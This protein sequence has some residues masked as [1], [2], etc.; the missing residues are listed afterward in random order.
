VVHHKTRRIPSYVAA[1]LAITF[2]VGCTDAAGPNDNIRKSGINV[3]AAS[4]RPSQVVSD[5]VALDVPGY[6]GAFVKNGVLNVYLLPT[7]N[8]EAGRAAARTAITDLL[9]AGNRPPM[10]IEF[11]PAR[12]SLR[13][14]RAWER[15]LMGIYHRA[16]VSRA[17]VDERN[18]RFD[19]TVTST[20]GEQDVRDAAARLGI[21]TEDVVVRTNEPPVVPFVDLHDRVRPAGGGLAISTFVGGC[22]Y[23]FNAWINDGVG[24]R[25]MVTN[26][27]CVQA[28]G[29]GGTTGTFV[30][31]PASP[32]ANQVGRV[33]RNPAAT[34]NNVNCAPGDVCRESDAALVYTDATTAFPASSWD[35]GGISATTSRGVGPNSNGSTTIS[36]RIT[37]AN[38]S[39][40]FFA[41]DTLEKIGAT[42]GWTAGVVTATC[43]YHTSGGGGRMCNGVVAAGANHGDSGSPVIWKDPQGAWHLIGILWGGP[44]ASPGNNSSEFWFSRF[45]GI[46]NELAFE[47]PLMV[48]PPPGGLCNPPP[49][50]SCP[51]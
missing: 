31:Q 22:T 43:V 27:H 11:I 29:F 49:G 30:Y 46:Q 19:V 44:D 7:A 3:S 14:L 39:T 41:G 48:T 47:G 25:Y 2:A 28:S 17:Q 33:S 37:L 36:G 8:N 4:L 13:E 40:I 32:A 1:I 6:G 9:V 38:A 24:G 16:G 12:H 23:G 26:A 21:P 34:P 10:P 35:I 18:N 5:R 45:Q 15:A 20:L 50:Q 42:T 51:K